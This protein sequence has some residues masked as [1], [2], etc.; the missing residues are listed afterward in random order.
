MTPLSGRSIVVTRPKRQAAVLAGLIEQAGG[1]AMRFPALEIEPVASP[2]LDRVI[3]QLSSFDLAIFISRNAVEHGVARVRESGAWP[4]GLAFAAIGAGTRRALVAEGI[5]EVIAPDGPADSEAL[6]RHIRLQ[7]VCGKRI[8]IFR[9]AGGREELAATLCSRGAVVDYAECY[10]RVRPATDARQLIDAWSRGELDAVTVSSGEGL[11]NLDALLGEQ[12]RSVLRT[13]PVFVSHP[14]VAEAAR[15]L[16]LERIVV[17]GAADEDML[18]A[19]VA[20]F[21]HSS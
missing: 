15:V 6:L 11:T 1:R 4:L 5:G 13:T 10:R 12:G 21:G 9:G 16:G 14:R 8:V 2:A 20:Y 18:R 19:L 3:A 17:A 7:W